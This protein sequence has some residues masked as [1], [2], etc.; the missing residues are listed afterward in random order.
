MSFH[1]SKFVH[2]NLLSSFNDLFDQLKPKYEDKANSAKDKKAVEGPNNTNEKPMETSSDKL[3]NETN[4]VSSDKRKT[5]P[6]DES[7]DEKDSTTDM[8]KDEPNVSRDNHSTSVNSLGSDTSSDQAKAKDEKLAEASDD[9]DITIPKA[10]INE[11]L[12]IDAST[13][14]ET[15]VSW[16]ALAFDEFPSIDEDFIEQLK[17]IV[18]EELSSLLKTSDDTYKIRVKNIDNQISAIN[19]DYDKLRRLYETSSFSQ[20][21]AIMFLFASPFHIINH[22]LKDYKKETFQ[23]MFDVYFFMKLPRLILP[24]DELF[25]NFSLYDCLTNPFILD[26]QLLEL[27]PDEIS[28]DKCEDTLMEIAGMI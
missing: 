17:I 23:D 12:N 2:D 26:V 13:S 9:L 16:D 11:D 19:F 15:K 8:S 18:G 28:D 10:S 22:L 14:V 3:L 27:N 6:T 20:K 24:F 1:W 21:R 7:L 4:E 5:E 25:S